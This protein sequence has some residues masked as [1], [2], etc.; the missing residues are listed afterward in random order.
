MFLPANVTDIGQ[1]VDDNIGKTL[2]QMANKEFNL[3][4]EK[5]DFNV[6]PK[7]TISASEKRKMTARIYN[8]VIGEFNADPHKQ[9]M[10]KNSANR[11]GMMLTIDG[12]NL[13]KFVPVK[14]S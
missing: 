2:K 9:S 5:F 13:D 7:G 3:E 12:D 4:L 11:T 8:K 1:F 6:N 14:Y 10:L